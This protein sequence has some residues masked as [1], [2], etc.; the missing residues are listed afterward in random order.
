MIQVIETDVIVFGGGIAGLWLFRCLHN[1]GYK[2]I[3]LEN[4]AL[5]GGQ[6]IKSQGIIHGGTK[7]TLSGTLTKASQCIAGMPDRWRKALQGEADVD[8]QEA[9]VLCPAHYLWSPGG[10]GSR[11][12]TFFASKALRGRVDQLKAKDFPPVFQHKN[13]RGKIY[14]LNE[15]VLDISSVV[16]ALSQG[17]ENYIIKTDW[18]KDCRLVTEHNRIQYV[19]IQQAGLHIH[20]NAKKYVTTAG[21]GTQPLMDMW[22]IKEPEMQVRPLHMVM[23][24]HR[25]PNPLYAHCIGTKAVPR[26]T[27]TSHPDTDNRWVWYLGGE[28]AEEGNQRSAEEQIEVAQ[29]ELKALLPWVPMDDAQWGTLRINRAEPRQHSLLR[30]DAAFCQPV[31]NSVICWPTKLALAP[32]LS[33]QV[34]S[35][36]RKSGVM[37]GGNQSFHMPEQLEHPDIAPSFWS[38]CFA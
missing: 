17:L 26:M 2:V 31:D 18:N 29:K 21:E 20:V 7:Y 30:P 14:Q 35:L 4:N 12:T 36:L 32:N 28:I 1:L 9:E 37:S 25:Y 6:T 16:K 34:L 15:I 22:G 38:E 11:L 3:L 27:I 10:L 13:F 23:V 33:D 24:R 5:G 8:L 19:D